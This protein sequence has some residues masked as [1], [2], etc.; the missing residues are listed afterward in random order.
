M[1]LQ[2]L[3]EL[4]NG[5]RSRRVILT[6]LTLDTENINTENLDTG[7]LDTDAESS[8]AASLARLPKRPRVSLHA[9]NE[10][11]TEVDTTTLDEIAD[12]TPAPQQVSQKSQVS[13]FGI[14]SEPIYRH[15]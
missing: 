11:V 8:L 10:T 2:H 1:C 12:A 13:H 7:N 9:A 15:Q 3:G 14:P 5:P 4:L 6:L